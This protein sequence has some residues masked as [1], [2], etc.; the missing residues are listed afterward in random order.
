MPIHFIKPSVREASGYGSVRLYSFTDLVQLRVAKTLKDKGL[1]LQ[2]IRKSIH[3]LKKAFPEL[4]K[5]LAEKKLITDGETIFVLTEEKDAIDGHLAVLSFF[6]EE[7]S[8][9]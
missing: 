1:S 5:P 7:D 8:S 9:F 4:E 3:Y 2:R 6:A